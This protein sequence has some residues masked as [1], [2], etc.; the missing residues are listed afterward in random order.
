VSRAGIPIWICRACGHAVFPQRLLC[1]NCG[2]ADWREEAAER[3][4]LEELTE[5]VFRTGGEHVTRR[6][7]SVRTDQ[8]PVVIARVLDD[9]QRGAAVTLALSDGA[10]TGRRAP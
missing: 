9:A 3:G 10:V 7:A 1:P 8:G 5:A 6:L 4:A 2:G